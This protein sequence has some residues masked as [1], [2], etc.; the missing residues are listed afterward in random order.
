MR[1]FPLLEH[2][3]EKK[4]A[5]IKRLDLF[6]VDITRLREN[7]ES[8][9]AD[10]K[11]RII[12][13]ASDILNGRIELFSNLKVDYGDSIKWN[14]NPLSKRYYPDEKWFKIPDFSEEYGDIKA[15]WEINRFSFIWY[16]LRA[17]ILTGDKLYYYKTK[18]L[19]SSWIDANKYSI[20]PN[21]KCGQE[22]ALRI[23]NVL[24]AYGTFSANQEIDDEFINLVKIFIS[25]NYKKIKR[26]HFYARHC[27]KIDHLISELCGLIACAW[28]CEDRRSIQKYFRILKKE[29]KNQFNPDGLYE[30]YSLNYQRYI[31][32]LTEYMLHI[33][34]KCDFSFD[35]ETAGLLYCAARTYLWVDRGKKITLNYGPNDGTLLFP[36]SSYHDYLSTAKALMTLIS[37]EDCAT[38]EEVIWFYNKSGKRIIA[39]TL[40]AAIP[41]LAVENNNITVFMNSHKYKRRPGHMDQLHVDMWIDGKNVFCDCGTYSY[42]QGLGDELR[43]T[44]G[45][46]TVLVNG[47]EQ[48]KT[49]GRF[50]LYGKPV[51]LT[52][53]QSENEIES[54]Q[55]FYTG[56][57]HKRKVSIKS[58]I[59]SISD[60]VEIK[61][62]DTNY[63]VLFHTPYETKK[64]DEKKCSI[65]VP[66]VGEVMLSTDNGEIDIS[67]FY[68]SR[69]YLDKTEI[70]EIAIKSSNKMNKTTIEVL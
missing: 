22:C 6:D 32:Q 3:F 5:D 64:L 35:A 27:V 1:V 46:N 56:Y 44:R 52:K 34:H 54:E 24:V 12:Q 53:L 23:L 50:L 20:G 58:N 63:F 59:V 39:D 9:P 40:T 36:I 2:F 66:E 55:K 14:Y 49:L 69:Y 33:S 41:F 45:H 61:G 4:V 30:S 8:L 26:N 21:Y 68:M 43:S 57:I 15:T 7:Y 65:K 47:K 29:I 18:D 16:L 70:T 25:L 13:K 48:M 37:G 67:P 42:T 11:E 10:E 31:L 17:Y 51:L 38:S 28:C 19:I 62:E 60:K